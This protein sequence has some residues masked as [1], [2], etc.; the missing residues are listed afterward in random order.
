MSVATV[1]AP[2]ILFPCRDQLAK[3]LK[4]YEKAI[5]DLDEYRG[6]AARAAADE[7]QSA[8]DISLSEKEAAQKIAQAQS[9]KHIY[10][11]RTASREKALKKGLDDIKDASNAAHQ[12]L[13]A[14]LHLELD[15]RHLIISRRLLEVLGA[16]QETA[17][18][19]AMFDL[20]DF[21]PVIRAIHELSV[22]PVTDYDEPGLLNKAGAIL[23]AFERIAEE[24]GK[25][26]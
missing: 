23:S 14:A 21:A 17:D 3:S 20:M 1:E 22:G 13:T 5:A 6:K 19:Q 12:E 16:V 7:E 2:A 4:A 8:D 10:S 9:M 25:E 26:I 15:R 18:S 24:K 11:A